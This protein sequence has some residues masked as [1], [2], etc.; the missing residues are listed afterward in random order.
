MAS[1]S[2]TGASPTW[3]TTPD[4]ASVQTCINNASNGD[5]VNVSAGSASWTSVTLSKDITLNGAGQGV[6]SGLPITAAGGVTTSCS[7]SGTC[8]DV[9]GGNPAFTITLSTSGNTRINNFAFL[10]ENNGNLPHTIEINGNWPTSYGLIWENDTFTVNNGTVIDNYL[11]GGVIFSGITFNGNWNDFFMTI[12]DDSSYVSWTTYADTIGNRDT[13]GLYNNYIEN[14][15]F[16]GGSNGVLDCDDN[17]RMVLRHNT[18]NESGGFNSHGDDSSPVGMRHFEIY[19]NSF[20]FPDMTCAGD[21]KPLEYQSIHLATRRNRSHLQQHFWTDSSCWGDKPE[22]RGSIRG[23]QDDLAFLPP[24]YTTRIASCGAVTYPAPNQLG[25]NFNGT[26]LFTD[27][28][29]TWGNSGNLECSLLPDSLTSEVEQTPVR[30]RG[31]LSSS[32]AGMP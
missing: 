6:T 9:S 26:S 20:N 22:I 28:I 27:P 15:T 12:K 19:D 31:A 3:T 4:Q 25:Q 2:C 14:S 5:T 23:I 30:L 8:I 1:A 7:S 32:G 11:P 13:T 24:G 17:C 10:V 16:N 18:F 29:Y 21:N